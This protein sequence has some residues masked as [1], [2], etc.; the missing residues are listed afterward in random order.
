[1]VNF[2]NLRNR[3]IWVNTSCS[4]CIGSLVGLFFLVIGIYLIRDT[5]NFLPGTVTAQGTIIQ[6]SYDDQH[7]CSPVIQFKTASGQS[8]TIGSSET[9]S[10][11]YVGKTVQVR[12]HPKTPQDGRMFSFM[13][14]LMLPLVFAGMGLL[15]FL[16]LPLTLLS[17]FIRTLF[18]FLL[19]SR[20]M[21]GNR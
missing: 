17:R 8:I 14:S 19:L 13:D 6:C 5:L 10:S 1:M 2:N 16:I 9:S 18:Q 7:N 21:S 3:R 4:G 15:V 11:F 20:I 12:Y